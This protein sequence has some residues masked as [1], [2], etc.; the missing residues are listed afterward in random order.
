MASMAAMCLTMN[1]CS[2]GPSKDGENQLSQPAQNSGTETERDRAINAVKDSANHDN[3][4]PDSVQ[5]HK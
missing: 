5:P 1:A 3:P 4:A 2:D